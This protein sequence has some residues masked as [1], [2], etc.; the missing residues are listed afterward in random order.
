MQDLVVGRVKTAR[1]FADSS[2]VTLL[3]IL[4]LSV[5]CQVLHSIMQ[6]MQQLVVL[7]VVRI[8]LL[9]CLLMADHLLETCRRITGQASGDIW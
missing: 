3:V 7:E 8:P 6:V 5:M 1:E 9:E 4:V 2:G